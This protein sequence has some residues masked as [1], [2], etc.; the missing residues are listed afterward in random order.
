MSP[1]PYPLWLLA[2]PNDGALRVPHVVLGKLPQVP[3]D[4]RGHDP[5]LHA[6]ERPDQVLS[7]ADAYGIRT[8][9]LECL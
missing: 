9:V 4:P 8:A 5:V 6:V 2:K 7:P 1:W 3:M